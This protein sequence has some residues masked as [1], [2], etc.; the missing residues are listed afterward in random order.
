MFIVFVVFPHITIAFNLQQCNFFLPGACEELL[1]LS[2][3]FGDLGNHIPLAST[4]K[5]RCS[6]SSSH[7]CSHV[8]PPWWPPH[9]GQDGKESSFSVEKGACGFFNA[10]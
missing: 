7:P 4:Y 8:L 3:G 2:T 1:R 6:P 9:L 5:G 10:L